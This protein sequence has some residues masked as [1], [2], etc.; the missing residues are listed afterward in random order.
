MTSWRPLRLCG[1]NPNLDKTDVSPRFLLTSIFLKALSLLIL[2]QQFCQQFFGSLKRLLKMRKNGTKADQEK[3][4]KP[5]RD[6]MENHGN[7]KFQHFLPA[8]GIFEISS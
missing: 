7:R 5:E 1:E 4:G 8:V 3:F 6:A 2:N